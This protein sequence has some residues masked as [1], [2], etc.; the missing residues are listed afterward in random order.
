MTHKEIVQLLTDKGFDHGWALS[1]T[2]LTV[3]E[4]DEEPPAPLT[5]PA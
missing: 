3:W 2:E 4:H 5:R 1:D